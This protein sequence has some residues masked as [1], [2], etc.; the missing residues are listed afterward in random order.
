MIFGVGLA[1]SE[2]TGRIRAQERDALSRE[3]RTST[4]Y[5]LARELS[6]SG[7]ADRLASIAAEHVSRVI[8]AGAVIWVADEEGALRVA[9]MNPESVE[10]DDKERAVAQWAFEH[11]ER[12]GMGTDTLAGAKSLCS[13]LLTS[14]QRHGVLMLLPPNASP[15]RID[16]MHFLDAV[17]RQVAAALERARLSDN[18]RAAA[19]RAE[20]ESL[21]SSLLSAVSHD[22]RTPLASIIGGAT[23]LR[24]TDVREL[25]TR[26]ELLDAI[27]DQAERMERLV[28]NLLDM[29]SLQAGAVAPR[30]TWVPLEELIGAALTRLESRLGNRPIRISVDATLPWLF[31]DPVLIEQ[32]FVNL[33]ENVHKHTP[34]DSPLEVRGTREGQSF[35]VQVKDRGPGLPPGAETRIF[36][37]FFRSAAPQVPGAGL[38]LAICK[39]VVEVHAGSID[40]RN[41]DG[42]GAVFT[43]RLPLLEPPADLLG[44][45]DAD[46]AVI[47][48]AHAPETMSGKEQVPVDQARDLLAPPRLG[49][50]AV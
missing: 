36:E 43:I 18:A 25:E 8:G 31:V 22:L 47:D 44:S 12:A 24:D 20:S 49:G 9:A 27:V 7:S 23:A 48:S 34:R 39:A 4:L 15:L 6:A 30:R 37:K 5:A 32:L 2:L 16:Q 11:S 14:G 29:T 46:D 1:V 41:R 10:I 13:P 40:A 38:G 3:E 21:R 42:G 45:D 50:E 26:G 17:A 28:T 35:V 19:L 33:F